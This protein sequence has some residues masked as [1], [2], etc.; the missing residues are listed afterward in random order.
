MAKF[1]KKMQNTLFWLF[2]PKFGQKLV[3]KNHALPGDLSTWVN[4][5][6]ESVNSHIIYQAL[7]YLKTNN[8][9]Y[10]DISITKFLSSETMFKLSNIVA[11]QGETESVTEK[12]ILDGKEMSENINGTRSETEIA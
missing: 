10:E 12:N 5:L 7:S 6:F 8:K 4:A 1:S 11:I 2:L 3:P 9:F